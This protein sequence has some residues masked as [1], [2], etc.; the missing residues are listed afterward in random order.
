MS[1]M[2]SEKEEDLEYV[3]WLTAHKPTQQQVRDNLLSVLRET[4]I[5]PPQSGT[6]ELIFAYLNGFFLVFAQIP[7]LL[8]P[9]Q[10]N[11]AAATPKK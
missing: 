11:F 6:C 9:Y 5:F 10:L 1:I 2:T 4:H 8:G 7:A 3:R